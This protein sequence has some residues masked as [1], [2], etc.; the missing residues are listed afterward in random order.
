M[1]YR[2]TVILF[3]C[4]L[5]GACKESFTPTVKT[6][7]SNLLVVEGFI[8]ITD[9]T[10][11]KLSRT[12][13]VADN[14]ITTN[15]EIGATLTIE[16]ETNQVYAL[17]EESA[18]LYNV[19]FSNLDRTK[20]HRLKIRTAKGVNYASD[21]T[22]AKVAPAIDDI[23]FTTKENGLQ[24][25][26]STKDPTNQS[27][28]YRWEFEESWIFNAKYNSLL[29]YKQRLVER[30][31]T[32]EN[33]FQCWGSAK[34]TTIVLGS[35]TKLNQDVISQSPLVF[36]PSESEK[37]GVKYSVLAKQYVLTKDAYEFWENL[38]KNTESLGSIFDAQP[39]QLT[40]NIHNVTDNL[41]P[42]IGYI[43]VGT[44]QAKRIFISKSEL[45]ALWKVKYPYDCFPDVILPINVVQ[46]FSSG[47]FIPIEYTTDGVLGISRECGDCTIRGTNKQPIF[48]R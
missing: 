36:I 26:V 19:P 15:P 16:S 46:T 39:S 27:K 32:T 14:K 31:P 21:F 34:S 10:F 9:S 44:M 43:G 12:V 33:I 42:V 6:T 11:I 47:K 23:G 1:G 3:I 8:N 37:I 25:H 35:S 2:L 41:E 7:N 29:I 5:F 13:T 24:V 48:W 20:K 28:Y 30:Q 17:K 40:G 45:P 38:R 18:G 22:E 4:I